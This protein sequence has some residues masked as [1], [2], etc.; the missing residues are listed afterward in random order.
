MKEAS[1]SRLIFA[2][3]VKNYRKINDMRLED[4]HEKCGLSYN[5]LSA[6]ENGRVNISLDNMDKI[7]FALKVPLATLLISG[8]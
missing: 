5:Y 7:A 4:L 1:K 8:N 3:Q 2:K 6:V